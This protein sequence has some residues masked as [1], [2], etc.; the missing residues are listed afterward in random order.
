MGVLEIIGLGLAGGLAWLWFDS[1]K[2]RE[3]GVQAARLACASEGVQ[4]LDETVAIRSLRPQ[5]NDYG[6]LLLRRIYSFEY[7]DTGDNR[8][9][10]SVVL[11]GHRVVVINVGESR[12]AAMPAAH[13]DGDAAR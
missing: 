4:L 13:A 2:A 1:L 12:P 5:R 3:I 11:L 7:S 10:G 9:P 6:R 8:R